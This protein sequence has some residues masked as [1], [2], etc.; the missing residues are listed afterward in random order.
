VQRCIVHLVR[1]ALRYV[2]DKDSKAVVRDLKEIY[3]AATVVEAE[4]ALDLLSKLNR[5]PVENWSWRKHRGDVRMGVFEEGPIRK[6]SPRWQVI[7]PWRS[8]RL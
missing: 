5:N 6:E 4:Q 2:A 3:Q 7:L 8:V 1:A